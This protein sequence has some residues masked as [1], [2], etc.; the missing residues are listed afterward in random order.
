MAILLLLLLMVVVVVGV[1]MMMRVLVSV[2][3]CVCVCVCVCMCDDNV[4]KIRKVRLCGWLVGEWVGVCLLGGV[5][6]C[7]RAH[8][9]RGSSC[10]WPS[11][12][13]LGLE[14]FGNFLRPQ[15]TKF[16]ADDHLSTRHCT[17]RNERIRPD[18]GR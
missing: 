4:K 11:L 5:C 16:L 14:S 1:M 3:V 9:R 7:A 18:T 13:N 12:L 2:F 17:H 10:T 6:A 15:Q 8:A